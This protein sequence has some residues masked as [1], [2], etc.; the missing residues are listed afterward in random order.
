[1]FSSQ[2]ERKFKIEG[3]YGRGLRL[4]PA[5]KGYFIMI[6]AGTGVTPFVDL[7]HFLFLKTLLKLIKKK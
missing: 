6:A 3:P 4:K 5:S 2:T 7:F 1:M